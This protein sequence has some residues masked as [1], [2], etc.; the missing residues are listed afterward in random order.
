MKIY[1]TNDIHS[2]FEECSKISK[3]LKENRT[4]EDLY[5]DCGDFCDLSNVMVHGTNGLGALELLKYM[6]V[7]ALTIGNNEI[8]LE[9]DAL[10]ALSKSGIP[11]VSCNVVDNDGNE[12][13]EVKRSILLNKNGMRILVI[14]VSPYYNGRRIPS[15]YNVFFEMGNL[16]T[17]DPY[18]EIEKELKT[19]EGQYDFCVLISHSGLI[20]EQDLL[21]RFPEINLCLG[22]H[23][24]HNHTEERYL[25]S[26]CYGE[27]L[28]CV[29]INEKKKM[30][31]LDVIPVTFDK[32]EQFDTKLKALQEVAHTNLNKTLYTIPKLTWSVT[33][34][35][36]Y[37][38]FI[39]D[40]LYLQDNCD[41][42]F[43][44]SGIV[45][46]GIEGNISK[47]LLLENSPSKLNPTKFPV[48]GENLL[49]AIQHSL[50]ET[51]VNQSG[52]GAGVRG[53]VL[54]TLAFSH[55]VQIQMN[56]LTVLI[57]DKPLELE[58]EYVCIADDSLQRGTG[59]TELKCVDQKAT[60]YRGFIRDLLERTLE[61]Q[62]IWKTCK[63]KRI[64]EK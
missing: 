35:N 24:H 26:G 25:Q 56:P 53:H 6:K 4:S 16:K 52:K 43:I 64:I 21:K 62:E 19:Y 12:I 37:S 48:K 27:N 3:Y 39:A 18:P 8:D 50:D 1:Q 23:S 63:I 30:T 7:D 15:A 57:D 54:G 17:I 11:F 13:G 55:N 29:T 40:A 33:K 58:K 60:F 61:N 9:H 47:Q 2:H 20:I 36:E 45:E 32:D 14:G 22:G 10:V 59:Y 5:F 34:E 41:L 49:L 31:N 51:F 38:N 44:N 46:G 28:G 42:A